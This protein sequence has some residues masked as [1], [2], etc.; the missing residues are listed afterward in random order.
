MS[1]DCF[2]K[3][4]IPLHPDKQE[5]PSTCLT[6]LGIKLDS[7]KVQARLPQDKFDR[8]IA[9]LEEWSQ[10][11]WCKRKELESLIGHLQLHCCTPRLLFLAPN[12][13]PALRFSSQ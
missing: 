1:I 3:L 13:Q 4:G 9:L 6:I 7:L 12:D 10:R 8:L 5:E 2:S 11:R